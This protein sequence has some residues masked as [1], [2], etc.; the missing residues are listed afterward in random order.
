MGTDRSGDGGCIQDVGADAELSHFKRSCRRRREPDRQPEDPR[1][2]WLL[3][4]LCGA[5]EARR[6]GS[7]RPPRVTIVVAFMETEPGAAMKDDS[8]E[9]RKS[10]QGQGC[11][12]YAAARERRC[13]GRCGRDWH[14]RGH[15]QA[16]VQR[17]LG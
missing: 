10:I 1:S 9:I 12:A 13:G 7:I 15:A 16:V 4:D 2:C 14:R 11:G 17:G 8:V 6:G 3:G 5:V